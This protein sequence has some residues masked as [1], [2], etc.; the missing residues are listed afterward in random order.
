MYRYCRKN[1]NVE[2]CY[3]GYDLCC[4]Q[5]K[6]FSSFILGT[7]V[8]VLIFNRRLRRVKMEQRKLT[9]QANTVADLA[10]VC[11]CSIFHNNNKKLLEENFLLAHTVKLFLLNLIL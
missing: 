8:T 7:K 3:L 2:Y 5:D 10:K 11:I 6:L 4:C 1:L 9:D